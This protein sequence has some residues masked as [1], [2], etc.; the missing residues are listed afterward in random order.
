[1]ANK[2]IKNF[3]NGRFFE[4]PRYQRGYAWERQHIQE[5]FDDIKESIESNSGHY[6]GTFVLSRSGVDDETFFIVDGQQRITTITLII[7]ALIKQLE[8]NDAA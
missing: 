5:L 3:F 8:S 4:I 2:M 7:S 1:M 6:I